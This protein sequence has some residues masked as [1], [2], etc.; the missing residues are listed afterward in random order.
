MSNYLLKL[1]FRSQM[2]TFYKNNIELNTSM[3]SNKDETP[4]GHYYKFHLKNNAHS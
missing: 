4:E 2:E 3:F 1:T